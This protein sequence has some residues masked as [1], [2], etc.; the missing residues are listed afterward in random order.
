MQRL[1]SPTL[2]RR[3]PT[4]RSAQRHKGGA[5]RAGDSRGAECTVG[6][7]PPQTYSDSVHLDSGRGF[8]QGSLQFSLQEGRIQF[9]ADQHQ[10]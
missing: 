10:A 2:A 8:A 3:R 6:L 5:R 4:R 1:N 9:G 7:R